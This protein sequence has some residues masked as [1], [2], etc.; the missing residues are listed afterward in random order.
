[1]PTNVNKVLK[2]ILK[3]EV[4]RYEVLSS[5]LTISK[6]YCGYYYDEVDNTLN[7]QKQSPRGVMWKRCS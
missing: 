4:R 6:I 7:I 3:T 2:T 5:E 1:M